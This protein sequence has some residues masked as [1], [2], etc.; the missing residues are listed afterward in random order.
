[1]LVIVYC[2]S[3]NEKLQFWDSK[4]SSNGKMGASKMKLFS[5]RLQLIK[6]IELMTPF[7][8]IF[9]AYVFVENNFM[10]DE[11]GKAVVIDS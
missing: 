1:M 4:K 9:F 8:K 2:H 10:V 7:R 5:Q 3:N 11:L 6:I